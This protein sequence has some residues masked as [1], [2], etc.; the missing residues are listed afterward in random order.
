MTSGIRVTC[1]EPQVRQVLQSW[2]DRGALAPPIDLSLAV[3][4][5]EPAV[6]P[7]GE[8]SLFRQPPV[9]IR[10]G[11]PSGNV[12]LSWDV[13]PA[14]AFLDRG[15]TTARVTL[16]PAA[17]A[18]IEECVRTFFMLVLIFLLRRAGWHHVHA[19][20]AIDPANRGWL[21]AGNAQAG[22]STTAAL[23]AS[24]GW[25]VGGDDTAF[26]APAGDRVTVIAFHTPIALR[27]GGRDLLNRP[28]GHP[29]P[30]RRKTAYWPEELGGAWAPRVEPDVIVFPSVGDAETRAVRLTTT[31]AMADLVR[32]SAWVVLEPDLAQEHLDLLGRLARQARSYRVSLGRDLFA[33]PERLTELVT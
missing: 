3:D 1:A 19:A 31:E 6:P 17:A 11:A 5:G 20:T 21:L 13:A 25:R 33:R 9:T 7:D 32:W 2:L 4:I 23:L 28:G 22:K 26:I 14:V 30:E 15:A 18:R 10:S 29:L 16:S 12:S 27:A 8:G 24:C